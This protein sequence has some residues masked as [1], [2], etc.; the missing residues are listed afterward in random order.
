[1]NIGIVVP[2]LGL[3]QISFSAISFANKENNAV[4]FFEQLIT[5]CIPIK[6]AT[7]CVNELMSF[8]GSLITTT[9]ESTLMANELI[10]KNVADHIFYVWDLEW[11]RPNKNNYL[12]NLKAYNCA[13]KL[14]ARSEEHADPIRNYC[15]RQPLVRKFEQVLTC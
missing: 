12:Y 9:I 11:L 6:C 2:H 15:N 5:P 4:L 14:I 13:D 7:M 10:N 1:M 3:S 8:R